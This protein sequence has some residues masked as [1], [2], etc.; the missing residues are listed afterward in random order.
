MYFGNLGSF[1]LKRNK[2]KKKN[3]VACLIIEVLFV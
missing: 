2:K 3:F 1:A